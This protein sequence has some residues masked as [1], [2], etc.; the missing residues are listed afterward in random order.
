MSAKESLSLQST[1]SSLVTNKR[2][3]NALKK[4][5]IVTIGDALTYY[6][7][8][9]TSPLPVTAIANITEDEPVSFVA[10]V[11]AT[12]LVSMGA[13]RGFRLVVTVEDSAYASQHGAIASAITLVFF[14]HKKSYVDWMCTRLQAGVTV[15]VG[16]KPSVFDGRIQMTHPEVLVVEQGSLATGIR[17]DVDTVSY[18]IARI[19]RPRPVY[20]TNSSISSDHI[21]D[22][23]VSCMHFLALAQKN[24]KTDEVQ[25][26]DSEIS[27]AGDSTPVI[28][29][30]AF[31]RAVPD[32]I[33]ESVRL[34]NNLLCRY[35]AFMSVH[36][37]ERVEDFRAA[38]TTLRYEEAFI[39]QTALLRSKY[40]A[41]DVQAYPCKDST[42]NGLYARFIS[43][44]P[45]TL[46]AGQQTVI[47]QIAHDMAQEYPMQRLLQGE[48]GSGKTV[49][50]IAAMLRAV[51]AGYQTV[52]VAPTQVLAEQ[53]VKSI[54]K[55][56]QIMDRTNSYTHASSETEPA[57]TEKDNAES[58]SEELSAE[59]YSGSIPV[60]LLSGGMRLAERRRALAVAASGQPC[61]VVATHAA[62]SKTFQAPRLALVVIDEQ[63][64][65]G[66]EQRE[67]L[68]RKAE[69]SPHLLVMTATPI[70][71]TAAMTWFGDLD[72]S[73]LTELP[74]GRK[75]TQTYIIS[76]ANSALMANMFILIR[77]RVQAGER[78]Y[79]V[80][81]R[82]S[83]DD[84]SNDYGINIDSKAEI[85]SS[86]HAAVGNSLQAENSHARPRNQKTVGQQTMPLHSVEEISSR[87]SH[88][89]QFQGIAVGTLTGRDDDITK[90]QVMADFSSGATPVLVATTVIEVGVDV[91]QAS[92]IVVFDADRFGLSQLHQ[93]RGRVGR[94]GL[95][96]WAFMVSRAE[97]NS[98]AAQRLDIIQKSTDG[99]R[100]AE[101]DI[102]LRG[103]G[104]VLGEAQ[105]GGH[106]SLKLLRVVE[107]ATIITHARVDAEK[108]LLDDPDLT[109]HIEL[110]GAVLDFMRGHENYLMTT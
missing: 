1:L 91:P 97:S 51:D 55:M 12:H 43:S 20:H 102:E 27:D 89:P 61:I 107:D 36:M 39:C 110:S 16:G 30:E 70:P 22:I 45:F 93:L 7:F 105:S 74:N 5:G 109:N 88:L 71:R 58:F 32:I 38:I 41:H 9:V 64:R 37:P 52:L 19:S 75:P 86:D 10:T 90:T 17:S 94:G 42:S 48:V 78:V 53:H 66:V 56:L 23:I 87:L 106:S 92:V 26:Q 18:G 24:S 21:H 46:T 2:R 77:Q 83:E 15:V 99:A 35:Q 25:L 79:I 65:F 72:I 101:A 31:A 33:P 96:S 104:D 4:L 6:P 60:V 69:K 44:L 98:V 28:D 82:I 34:K 108:L 103:A 100:I 49:V 8:R 62:F 81:P 14:S 3:V 95:Q 47:D 84:D 80:C 68:R 13:N 59:E 67:V 29:T 54:T 57:H 73:E 11:E 85:D 50:A 76:E 63:H 40:Q